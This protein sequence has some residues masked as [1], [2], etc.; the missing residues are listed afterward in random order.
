MHSEIEYLL[1]FDM[2]LETANT[3]FKHPWP[4]CNTFCYTT[5][6]EKLIFGA[7]RWASTTPDCWGCHLHGH[8]FRIL[9]MTFS[10]PYEGIQ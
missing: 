2:G 10:G 9:W 4:I 6:A 5:F 3:F 1:L 7:A 8:I